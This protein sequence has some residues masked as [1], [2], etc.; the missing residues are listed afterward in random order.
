[1]SAVRANVYA[2]EW[3]G[4]EP[5][6]DFLG[7]VSLARR[8]LKGAAL[9]PSEY[10]QI[11]SALTELKRELVRSYPEHEPTFNRRSQLNGSESHAC[12]K[13]PPRFRH[14]SATLPPGGGQ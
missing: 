14:A 6:A 12:V 5:A 9:K 1:M 8:A 10:R 13:V 2:K 4:H 3:L 7:H 11:Q